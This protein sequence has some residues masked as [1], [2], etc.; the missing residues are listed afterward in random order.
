MPRLETCIIENNK[1]YC[2]DDIKQSPVEA[3]LI[4]KD[5][6]EKIPENVFNKL[7]LKL[8]ETRGIK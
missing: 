1:I 4:I 8:C 2:W 5:T 3:E 7:L 6:N